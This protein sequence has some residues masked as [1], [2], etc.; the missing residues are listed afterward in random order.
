M[1]DYEG[2]P[3]SLLEAMACGVVPVARKIPSGIPE[4]VLEGETGLLV[5]ASPEKAASALIRLL[6]DPGPW[7]RCSQASRRLIAEKYG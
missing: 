1:S 4:L 5:D 2:L 6:D 3:I 7:H